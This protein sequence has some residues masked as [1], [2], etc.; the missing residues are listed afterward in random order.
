VLKYF[1]LAIT[2]T[3]Q[4]IYSTSCQSHTYF[5]NQSCTATTKVNIWLIVCATVCVCM[6]VS[7]CF[8]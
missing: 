6:P 5:R 1:I 8:N 7:I 4:L 3:K 2:D